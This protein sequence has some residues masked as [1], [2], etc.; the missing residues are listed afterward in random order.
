MKIKLIKPL[1]LIDGEGKVYSF[2][3]GKT[4]ELADY[5]ALQLINSGEAL[6]IEKSDITAN[7]TPPKPPE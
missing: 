1:N 3:E 2:K 6:Q 5:W 4:Y 7:I